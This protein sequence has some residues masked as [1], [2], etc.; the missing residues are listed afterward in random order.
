MYRLVIVSVVLVAAMLGAGFAPAGA[1]T[2]RLG[3][4]AGPHAQ[5]A[6]ALVP[7]AKAKGLDVKVVEF[8]DGALIDPA[9]DAGDLDAN[10][11]QHGPYLEQ[12]DHDRGLDIVSVARTILLPMAG[13]SK[14]VKKLADLP[15]GATISIPNDPTNGGRALKLL[16]A[17]GMIKLKPGSTY[18]ATELDIVD[19]PKK[20]K[21]LALDTGQLPRSLEDV[22]FSVITSWAALASGLTP[23]GDGVL[24]EDQLSDYFC[25]IGVKRSRAN[26]PWVKILA[27]SYR[28]PEVKAFIA[29][30]FKGNIIASW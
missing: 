5:V 21:I 24:V 4:T 23:N 17:G 13:Y 20:V 18:D 14:K 15:E 22:D 25:L 12:Q 8:S 11:F 28:S 29:Q 6:E 10:A 30:T 1:Q 19:N 3:V 2:I 9:T 16:E 26:E 7:I 27:D